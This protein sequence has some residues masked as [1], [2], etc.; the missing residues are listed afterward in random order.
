MG[1][2]ISES[3]RRTVQLH[4]ELGLPINDIANAADTTVC[5][6]GRI[7]RNM[8]VFGGARAPSN[9]VGRKRILSDH[10]IEVRGNSS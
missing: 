4:L 8:K 6:V 2:N 3:Q 1:R 7:R 10:Q 9:G 5:T